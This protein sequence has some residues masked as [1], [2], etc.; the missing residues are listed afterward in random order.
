MK[1]S[2]IAAL[3]RNRVIGKNNDLPWHLPDDMKYF[4]TTTQGHYC[5]M[6]RK[7]YDSIPA[8]FKPLPNR[9]NI[10]VTHQDDFQAPG[11]T[12]VNSIEAA[13]Q[14]AREGGE[15]EA[16]VIGGAEIYRA[17][18]AVADLLYLTEI[19][20][21]IPGDV[22]FPVFDK[23]AWREISRQHHPADQR[24]AYAFDFVVYERR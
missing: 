11:C 17:S 10:V 9:T 18:L 2:L 13:L 20:A 16:F 19:Q 8:K 22:Q 4:M 3:A 24:H 21:E 6:G 15:Q 23:Q 12:V 1:I 7:N 5:I 14:L